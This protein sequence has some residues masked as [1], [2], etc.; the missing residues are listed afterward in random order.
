M[1]QTLTIDRLKQI[2]SGDAF[3]C[4]QDDESVAMALEL[5][6]Y[7]EKNSVLQVNMDSDFIKHIQKCSEEVA[8]WPEWKRKGADVT[9]FAT[10][11][12][13]TGINENHYDPDLEPGLYTTEIKTKGGSAIINGFHIDLPATISTRQVIINM[14]NHEF[15][16]SISVAYKLGWNDCCAKILGGV[17][18]E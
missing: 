12:S 2:A 3:I 5:L 7:R 1:T 6:K 17:R 4:T 13:N 14:E 9:Q 11:A 15:C 18:D 16:T 10:P 8:T